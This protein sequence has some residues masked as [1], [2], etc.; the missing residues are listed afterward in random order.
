M[1][2]LTG[3]VKGFY[4][5][6]NWLAKMM[7]LHLLW[8]IFTIAG[9]GVFGIMPATTALVTVLHKR[10]QKN[11][12]F[13]IFKT[14]VTVYKAQFFKANGLG[15]LLVAIGIFLF[16]DLKIAKE[17]IHSFYLYFFLIFICFLY[18]ITVLHFF[19]IYARYELTFIGYYKQS[20]AM[21]IAR[22]FETISMI[23]CMI[24]VYYLFSS[25][26]GLLFFIG[27]SLTAYP[28]VYFGYRACVLVEEKQ[29]RL[30][31]K[32]KSEKKENLHLDSLK[33]I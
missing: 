16:Q 2:K 27:S 28:I 29:D 19:I 9:L 3:L 32:E 17:A 5:I 30:L 24:L 13:P 7:Y 20:F 22:P 21:A 23:I 10:F 26:P 25:M 14:F 18:F 8:C 31:K 33:G 6:G 4:E 1:P 12:E 15:L 11:V